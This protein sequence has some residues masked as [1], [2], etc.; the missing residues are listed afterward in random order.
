MK[1]TNKIVLRH[2]EKTAYALKFLGDYPDLK[3]REVSEKINEWAQAKGIDCEWTP[4]FVSVTK[5]NKKRA[6]T[7]HAHPLPPIELQKE[8]EVSKGVS[9][10]TIFELFEELLEDMDKFSDLDALVDFMQKYK[11][12]WLVKAREFRDRQNNKKHRLAA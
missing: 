6:K 4:A 11:V 3:T 5:S 1:T 2:G 9:F 8:E 7:K 12:E 10:D